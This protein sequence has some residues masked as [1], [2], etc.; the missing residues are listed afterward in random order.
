LYNSRWSYQFRKI[1]EL[2][3][4]AETNEVQAADIRA[5]VLMR[6]PDVKFAQGSGMGVV[7]VGSANP[8]AGL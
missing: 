3:K 1:D 6:G 7:V 8:S 4:E 2:A 5:E